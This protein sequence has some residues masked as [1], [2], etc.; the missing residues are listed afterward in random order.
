MIE[1]LN[2]SWEDA[3]WAEDADLIICDPIYEQQDISYIERFAELLRPGG[4]MYV[5][6]D[7]HGIA[8]TKIALD[9]A[10]LDFQNWIVW[11][12]NDWGG[13][14]K[15]RWGQKHDDLLF[16]TKPGAEHT[17]NA[18]AVQVPKK[19]TKGK[20]NPSGRTH[21]IPNS[22]WDDLGVFSTMSN[23]RVKQANGTSFPW[24]KPEKLIER[25]VLA[26]S[27]EGDVVL[28]PFSGVAT[29][30]VVC[31]RHNRKCMATEQASE[32]YE[33]GVKRLENMEWICQ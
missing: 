4:S 7:F 16:Y 3:D 5:F 13:R 24:Q 33:A 2:M 8:E 25:I 20:F 17:F 11:G 21:K 28:D 32:P 29:V 9:W 18:E 14:S 15:T 30:P 23:E 19:M 31:N 12:P 27:N 6:G 26:S 1:Y 10:G 22:V